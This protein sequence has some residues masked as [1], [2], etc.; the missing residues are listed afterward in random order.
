MKRGCCW[1]ALALVLSGAPARALF[2]PNEVATLHTRLTK[3]SV[4]ERREAAACLVELPR[5][6]ASRLALVA[7]DDPDVDVR[8]S[9]AE[10]IVSIRPKGSSRKVTEWLTSPESRLR[11]AAASVLRVLPV[12]EA[13]P[14]LGRALLDSD[15]ALRAEA[16]SALAASKSAEAV[17]PLLGR[18]DDSTPHVRRAVVGALARLRDM[19]AVIPLIGKI[20]DPEPTVRAS[21]ARALGELGDARAVSA[22]VLVLRDSEDAVKVAALKALGQL[23]AQS[24][25]R[26]IVAQL[27]LEAS[28]SVRAAAVRALAGIASPSSVALLVEQLRTTSP[29]AELGVQIREAL[30]ELGR[31]AAPPL[32]ECLAGQPPL[33]LADG[34]ALGLAGTGDPDAAAAVVRAL[35]ERVV[36]PDAGLEAL[37]KIGD[38]SALPV[39]LEY[40]S[41]PDPQLRHT[42]R[43]ACL[44]LLDPD[45][46]DGRAV[47]PLARALRAAGTRIDEL[48]EIAELLGRTGSARAARV[49]EPLATR[50]DDPDLQAASLEALGHLGRANASGVLL[51]A[52]DSDR[53]SVRWAAAL[54]LR[55]SGDPAAAASLVAR[56]ERGAEQERQALAVA[57]AGALAHTT[58]AGLLDRVE[59]LVVE[60]RSGDRDALMEAMGSAEHP[61]VI[62]RLLRL[63]ASLQPQDR[64]KIAEAL[65]GHADAVPA[66]ATLALDRDS[67]VRANAA[68]SLG[69]AGQGDQIGLLTSMLADANEAVAANAAAA[70][71][72]LGR[73]TGQAVGAP[74]CG[75]LDDAR[76]Y[77]RANALA[78][79]ALSGLVCPERAFELL[80][81]DRSEQ[82][83]ESAVLAL[84][85]APGSLRESVKR[86]LARCARTDPSSRVADACEAPPHLIPA[87]TDPVLVYAVPAGEA[88]PVAGAPFA[89]VL[90]D[91]LTRLG[92]ADRRGAIFERSAPRGHV[93]LGAAPPSSE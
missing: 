67:A 51:R 34:C 72:R 44:A 49:L 16:A 13:V 68:W 12:A 29:H 9:A 85:R 73:R 24:A 63:S 59:R 54:A 57:L 11:L 58:D 55:H 48:L 50:S 39:V 93:R 37:A 31:A 84:G 76:S 77:V 81:Y 60:S 78:A 28:A 26:S 19:R 43:A 83:R 6:V 56:L 35:R 18:L 70:L 62:P 3:G 4:S 14:A 38:R 88:K 82:V 87:G 7:L 32:L 91:G 74:L 25:E 23:K 52:L 66:L 42:A 15:P 80:E 5:A 65:A 79:L 64:A 90:A 36:R 33:D 40:L 86:A 89:L 27:E 75:A 10:A 1:L 45:V 41:V 53:S 61:S 92:V 30:H 69:V 71:G 47:E 2:W 46:P 8:L 21:V 17:V 22:L 20:E